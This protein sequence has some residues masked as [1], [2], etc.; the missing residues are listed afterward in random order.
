[1]FSGLVKYTVRIDLDQLDGDVFL[2]LGATADV[3]IQ[4]KGSNCVFGCTYRC[5]AK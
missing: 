3:V 5:N 2:P 1:M 4:S